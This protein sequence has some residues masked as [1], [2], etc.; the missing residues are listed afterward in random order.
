MNALRQSD[1]IELQADVLG[2]RVDEER[3]GVERTGGAVALA[4]PFQDL[5][6]VQTLVV[7]RHL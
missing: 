6:A 1:G 7:A 2:Q 4:Q 5:V 3:G